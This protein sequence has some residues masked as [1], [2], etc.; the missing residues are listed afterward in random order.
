MLAFVLAKGPVA[1]HQCPEHTPSWGFS[2]YKN[3]GEGGEDRNQVKVWLSLFALP[4]KHCS[5]GP[6][7]VSSPPEQ[8]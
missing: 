7:Q 6:L 2:F 1:A 3:T 5:N 4:P 8:R